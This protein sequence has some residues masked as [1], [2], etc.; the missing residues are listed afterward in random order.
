MPRHAEAR[1]SRSLH[2]EHRLVRAENAE[3]DAGEREPP[4]RG[5]FR[6]ERGGTLSLTF[7]G[8][9]HGRGAAP[10]LARASAPRPRDWMSR[11]SGRRRKS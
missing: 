8:V 7:T 1:S 6:D 9:W 2:V 3:P 10:T 5:T 11:S 4:E